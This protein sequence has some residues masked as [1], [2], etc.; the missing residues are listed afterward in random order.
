M[1]LSPLVISLTP[2]RPVRVRS[3]SAQSISEA[4]RRV[5]RAAELYL[6]APDLKVGLVSMGRLIEG[7]PGQAAAIL[8]LLAHS[9][10][11]CKSGFHT[12]G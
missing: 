7:E 2:T 8:G 9:P 10:G 6:F 11:V 12:D 3:A 5:S 4:W 1:K